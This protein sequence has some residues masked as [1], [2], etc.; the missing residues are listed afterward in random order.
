MQ[1]FIDQSFLEKRGEKNNKTL[2]TL[3]WGDKIANVLGILQCQ[4]NNYDSKYGRF[5]VHQM[6]FTPSKMSIT[7]NHLGNII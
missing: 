6:L 3:Y 2:D 7:I 5:G 1:P 4:S